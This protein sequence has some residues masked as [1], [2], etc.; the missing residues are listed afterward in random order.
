MCYHSPAVA[1]DVSLTG[2]NQDGLRNGLSGNTV[3]VYFPHWKR[4]CMWAQTGNNGCL[5]IAED[6][7]KESRTLRTAGDYPVRKALYHK[8]FDS[9]DLLLEYCIKQRQKLLDPADMEC[10]HVEPFTSRRIIAPHSFVTLRVRAIM[11]EIL[12]RIYGEESSGVRSAIIN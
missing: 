5:V 1:I 3:P 12:K 8:P 7:G 6:P 11:R 9:S 4:D 10:V 2:A